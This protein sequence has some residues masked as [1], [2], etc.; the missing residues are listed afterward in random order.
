MLVRFLSFCATVLG[1]ARYKAIFL[2]CLTLVVALSGVSAVALM[3]GSG[4]GTNGASATVKEGENT[5]QE[6]GLAPHLGGARKQDPK[7]P[8][9]QTDTTETP[10]ASDNTAAKP[11]ETTPKPAE[12]SATDVNLSATDVRL[13]GEESKTI[14]VSTTDATEVTWSVA[15]NDQTGGLLLVVPTDHQD[16]TL[17]FQ[18]KADKNT[19]HIP[20]TVTVTAKDAVRNVTITKQITVTVQ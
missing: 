11:A 18:V 5:D 2:S 12:T 7:Q 13:T 4:F 15:V 14:T 10:S 17:T 9:E 1:T 8:V 20:Y 16:K 3:K 19:D 6:S